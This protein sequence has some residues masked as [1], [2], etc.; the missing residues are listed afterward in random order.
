MYQVYEY[1][2]NM[3]NILDA[4]VCGHICRG[5]PGGMLTHIFLFVEQVMVFAMM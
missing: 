1:D 2:G 5:Q 3:I 4:A